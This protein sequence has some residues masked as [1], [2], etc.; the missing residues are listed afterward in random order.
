[1]TVISAAD[2]PR[3]YEDRPVRWFLV[4]AAVW[5]VVAAVGSLVLATLLVMPKLFYDL[6]DTAQHFSFGRLYPTQMQLVVYGV[7]GNGF[8]GFAYYAVQRLEKVRLALTPLAMLHWFVWQGL[9]IVATIAAVRLQ[10]E[11]RWLSWMEWPL[12]LWLVAIW[13]LLFAPVI[14][15]TLAHRQAG[16][17]LSAP[18]WFVLAVM[19]AI[20]LLYLIN[21]LATQE[22]SIYVGVQDAMLQWWTG[23]GLVTYWMTVP[24]VAM[25]YYLVP[26]LGDGRLHSHRLTVIHFWSIVLLGVWGGN[27]QW[28]LTVVPEWADS[29]GMFVGLL[30]WWGCLAGAYNLWL[31]L[32]HSAPRRGP[33]A[34]RSLA[35]AAVACYAIYSLD[36]AYMSLKSSSATTQFTDWATANQLL[37][38]LGVSGLAL[39]AFSL[40]CTAHSPATSPTSVRGNWIRHLAIVGTAIQVIALY[41]AGCTQAFAWNHLNELGRL[42]QPEFVTAIEW[43][44]PFWWLAAIGAAIWLIA[45]LAWLGRL[46]GA[47]SSRAAPSCDRALRASQPVALQEPVEAPSRLVD[48]PVLAA[49]VKLEHWK[50]LVWHASLERRPRALATRVALLML[51]GIL[52]IWLPSFL[53]RG[54]AADTAA[55]L[56]APYTDLERIGRE[57]YVREGC[58]SC[59]TQAS[60]PLVA[61]VQRYGDYSRPEDYAG[62]RPTQ[63]GFRRVG[64][65]LSKEGGRQTSFWHWKHLENPQSESPLSVMPAFDYLLDQPLDAE[66]NPA[67]LKQ[68]ESLA[69]DIVGQGG[70]VL[71]GD[72]LLMNSRGIALVAYLQRLGVTQSPAAPGDAAVA[73]TAPGGT[74]TEAASAELAQ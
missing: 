49:A 51:P 13:V 25:L 37:A 6:G 2:E 46:A 12:D 19:L 29:L 16:L 8:F 28:H 72:R 42:E 7:L 73:A 65:D 32:N 52:L 61:E 10:T 20:P 63:I 9:I 55:A 18:L 35:T 40:E 14:A 43:V 1:M 71:Y 4:V 60:R 48:A 22:G 44:Q 27:F 57:I 36:S 34:A 21:N 50:Q 39:I 17:R 41:I 3:W 58:V 68:A 56:T 66:D 11:G 53:Y 5:A 67:I 62:D 31:S 15:A 47:M 26:K 24:A 33:L 54:N 59:H 30:L 70:P 64:P 45:M 69:A 23:R 38:I 74:A